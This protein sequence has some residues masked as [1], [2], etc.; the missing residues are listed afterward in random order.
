MR[1]GEG[2]IFVERKDEMNFVKLNFKSR[3]SKAIIREGS[4]PALKV[5]DC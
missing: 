2:S 3:V 5:Q 4:V 1:Q